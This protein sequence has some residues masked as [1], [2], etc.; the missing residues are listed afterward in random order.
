MSLFA[1]RGFDDVTVADITASAGVARSTFFR[2]FPDKAEVLFEDDSASHL[3]LAKAIAGA[4]RTLAPLGDDLFVSLRVAHAACLVLADSKAS[5]A[6]HHPIREQLIASVPQ[7]QA[8]SLAKERE[9]TDVIEK[10]L[11]DQGTAPLIARQAAHIATACY[12]AGYTE[13]F[14]NPGYLPEAVDQAFRR[15]FHLPAG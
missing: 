10:A 2:Y 9:Y 3:L 8:C 14:T 7:L 4:A 1:E 12:D 11:R 15:L 13:A 6:L 5:Q